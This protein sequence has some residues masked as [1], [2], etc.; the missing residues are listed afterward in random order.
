MVP[1]LAT[2][3]R[4]RTLKLDDWL[5][6]D[7]KIEM[8]TTTML[9]ILNETLTSRNQNDQRSKLAQRFWLE[10]IIVLVRQLSA[11]ASSIT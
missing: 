2:G 1:F 3:S 9:T 5:I 7:T 6:D 10:V 11:V 8:A 4:C